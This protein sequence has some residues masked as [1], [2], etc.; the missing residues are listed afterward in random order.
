MNNTVHNIDFLSS[1]DS[2]SQLGNKFELQEEQLVMQVVGEYEEKC[3]SLDPIEIDL[4]KYRGYVKFMLHVF[5]LAKSKFY[6]DV[7]SLLDFCD[8]R[9]G[10]NKC[11]QLI[12]AD[13]H[14]S[15]YRKK[16]ALSLY[17]SVLSEERNCFR[18]LR[19]LARVHIL[20][21]DYEH[22]I[23]LLEK[24]LNNKPN[25]W[26]TYYL[27]GVAKCRLGHVHEAALAYEKCAELAP[28]FAP[29]Y[30][31]LADI[32]RYRRNDNKLFYEYLDSVRK[33]RRNTH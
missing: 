19:G 24:S 26:Y 11:S 4:E 3:H 17:V 31:R 5:S 27:L 21:K 16:K 15:C 8:Q 22:A 25:Q 1:S 14:A 33:L 9:F 12:R 2:L 29:V 23:Y 20:D 10:K 13:I 18:G 32:A 6:D 7:T 30:R 28:K